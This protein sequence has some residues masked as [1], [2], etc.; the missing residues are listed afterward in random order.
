MRFSFR[1]AKIADS[2]YTALLPD[3][4]RIPKGMEI[5]QKRD[6][7]CL[8]VNV[9]IGSGVSLETLISTLDEFLSHITSITHTLDKTEELNDRHKNSERLA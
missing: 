4:V 9:Q 7:S 1:D 8:E 5:D 3:N 2:V 6:D